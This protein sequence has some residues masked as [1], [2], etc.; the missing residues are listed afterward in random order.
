MTKKFDKNLTPEKI[1]KRVERLIDE[2]IY[3]EDG[4]WFGAMYL[5]FKVVSLIA[6]Q[7]SITDVEE[8][9]EKYHTE[10]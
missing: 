8:H 4:S 6:S 5:L 7:H 2:I 1:E 3:S 10:K 9:E